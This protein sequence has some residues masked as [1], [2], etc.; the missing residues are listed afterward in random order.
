MILHNDGALD[1]ELAQIPLRGAGG[2]GPLAGPADLT[3][4]IAHRA[5][6]RLLSANAFEN[7]VAVYFRRDGLTGLRLLRADGSEQEIAFPEPLYQVSPGSNPEYATRQFRLH[8]ASLAT[9]DSV[10]DA[11]T[12]TGELTLRKRQPVL[13]LPGQGRYD[14]A[15]FEQQRE[16]AVAADG[17]RVP[18]SL[19]CRAG[20]PRTAARRWCSTATA[21]TRS[22][23]IPASRSRGYRC[24]T[25]VR[26]RDRARPGRRG[27]GPPLVRRQDAAQANTFTDF[28]ACASTWWRRAGPARTGDRPGRSAGGLLM[29]AV[30]NIARGRSA[31]SRPGPVRGR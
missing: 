27:D 4:V 22:R 30:A 13:P 16:W 20:T 8:Y 9:P 14:P 28:V 21:A 31:D 1:F 15:A 29:G 12:L 17:T 25:G 5:G 24:W 18:I 11:D 7:H 23:P 2:D 26:L 3:T 10:Y 19:I 6:T